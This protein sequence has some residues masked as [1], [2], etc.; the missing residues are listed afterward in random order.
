MFAR[1]DFGVEN[2]VVRAAEGNYPYHPLLA[3][4]VI[5]K[6]S[7]YQNTVRVVLNLEI[8][9]ETVTKQGF[10][11]RVSYFNSSFQGSPN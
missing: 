5:L 2:K 7:W 11:R 8:C 6:L 4:V 3:Q 9:G 10:D 1:I